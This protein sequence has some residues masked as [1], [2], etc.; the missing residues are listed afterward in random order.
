M[1]APLFFD[2]G[3]GVERQNEISKKEF[4]FMCVFGFAVVPIC[5]VGVPLLFPCGKLNRFYCPAS[6]PAVLL[7]VG[8]L[9]MLRFY[10][11]YIGR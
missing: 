10:K 5:S 7:T 2:F 9:F 4:G 11:K 1:T 6:V 3:G 8:L